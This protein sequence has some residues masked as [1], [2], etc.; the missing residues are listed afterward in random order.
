MTQEEL[1]EVTLRAMEPEDLDFLYRIENDTEVW[2]VGSTNVPYSR[3]ALHEYIAC[4]KNDIYADR[5]VRLIIENCRKQIVGLVD[6]INFDPRNMRAEIGILIQ[7][8]HRRKGYAQ[9]ALCKLT[10]HAFASLHLHQLYAIIP[11]EN[12]ASLRLFKT[13]GFTH[14]ATL[15]DW[16]HSGNGYQKAYLLAKFE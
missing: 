15:N 5:Q 14:T 2:D 6:L 10:R 16:L 9:S 12:D 8:A 13:N 3:Y 1:P 11:E 7:K 4:A